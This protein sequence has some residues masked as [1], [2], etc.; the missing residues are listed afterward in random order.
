MCHLI[1]ITNEITYSTNTEILKAK[2]YFIISHRTNDKKTTISLQVCFKNVII[3][4]AAEQ[5]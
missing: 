3:F 4:T 1:Q 2:T 5:T